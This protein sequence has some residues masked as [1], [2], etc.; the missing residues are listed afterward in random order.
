MDWQFYLFGT[1]AIAALVLLWGWAYGFDSDDDS[2]SS[3]S[4]LTDLEIDGWRSDDGGSPSD[5]S[6]VTSGDRD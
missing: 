3:R 6:D 5:S 4:R 2:N 1:L